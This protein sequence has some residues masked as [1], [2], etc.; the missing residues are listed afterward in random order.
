MA[1]LGLSRDRICDFSASI[2]PLGVPPAVQQALHLALGRI[3]DYPE[4]D[5]ESLRLELARFHQLPQEQL[6]PGSGSTELIYLLP[7]VLRPRRALLIRPCFGEYAPALHQAGCQVDYFDLDPQQDFD[8]NAAAI[9]A[10]LR[11]ETDLLLLANP[12]NPSGLAVDPQLLLALAERLGSC[13]LLVDEAFIDFCPQRSLLGQL[14]MPGNLLVLRSLTKIYAIPGLRVGYLAG[15]AADVALLAA[16][17]EP[18]S[19]S[20]LA[21]AAARACLGAEDF[22]QHSLELIPQLRAS[23]HQGLERLGW[24]VFAGEANYLLCR[25]PESWPRAA[26]VV[27]QLR[28]QGL[29]VRGCSDFAPLDQTYLR[30]AVLGEV[31][32]QRLLNALGALAPNSG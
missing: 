27:R 3:S 9:L 2:N 11:P 19:L 30:I 13:R 20:N 17:R 31:Q 16:A 6:L 22:R 25:L 26:E 5:A 7:R 29:L 1:E 24:R 10:A 23:L 21:I 32:N 4:A 14:P 15:S 18:W 12:G 28:L 8:F